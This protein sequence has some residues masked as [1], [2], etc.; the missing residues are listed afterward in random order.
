MRSSCAAGIILKAI[1]HAEEKWTQYY[2]EERE[3]GLLRALMPGLM[4]TEED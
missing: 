1:N 3:I 4:Y 2:L